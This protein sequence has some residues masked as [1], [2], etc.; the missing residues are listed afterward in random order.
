MNKKIKNTLG[1]ASYISYHWREYTFLELE[2]EMANLCG[3]AQKALSCDSITDFERGQWSV[4][5]NVIGFA[6]NYQMA[7][8]LCHEAS[9][10]R[11]KI[12]ELQADCGYSFD[13]E[14]S[15]F[16]N[17]CYGLELED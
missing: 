17:S 7:A 10:G 2:K 14:V 12:K 16:L 11:K 5:Q 4:I 1:S 13:E 9:I 3:M 15:D 6:Q 8:E